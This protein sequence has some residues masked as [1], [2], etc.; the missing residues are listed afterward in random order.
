MAHITLEVTPS[1]MTPS[2]LGDEFQLC[3]DSQDT[4][5]IIEYFRLEHAMQYYGE[6]RSFFVSI[7]DG[8]YDTVYAC[9]Y[10]FPHDNDS[11]FKIELVHS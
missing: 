4:E 3:S 9:F 1:D 11:L 7:S 2:M 5:S 10:H 8:D 6:F